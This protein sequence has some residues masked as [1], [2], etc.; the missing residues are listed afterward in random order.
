MTEQI[1]EAREEPEEENERWF[2]RSFLYNC[3]KVKSKLPNCRKRTRR[4]YWPRAQS[5][6]QPIH[7]LIGLSSGSG[8]GQPKVGSLVSV[9]KKWWLTESN[10]TGRVIRFFCG[11]KNTLL[12]LAQPIVIADWSG[13]GAPR[14]DWPRRR[15]LSFHSRAHWHTH[16]PFYNHCEN[17]FWDW[18]EKK[19]VK[20]EA[21]PQLLIRPFSFDER[22]DQR[23]LLSERWDDRDV[24][25]LRL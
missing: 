2:W 25:F 10:M 20:L 3:N 13:A 6:K 18:T 22:F 1:E 5:E 15:L 14:A 4:V 19:I 9:R 12:S 8:R 7:I 21:K 24:L 23:R 17:K 16:T 11:P